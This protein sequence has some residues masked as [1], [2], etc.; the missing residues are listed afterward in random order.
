MKEIKKIRLNKNNQWYFSEFIS[1]INSNSFITS[2]KL[3]FTLLKVLINNKSYS[4]SNEEEN[5]KLNDTLFTYSMQFSEMFNLIERDNEY[6]YSNCFSSTFEK[7]FNCDIFSEKIDTFF[8]M[9][10]LFSDLINDWR[11]IE[12][13]NKKKC[14]TINIVKHLSEKANIEPDEAFIDSVSSIIDLLQKFNVIDKVDKLFSVDSRKLNNLKSEIYWKK[15]STLKKK[16]KDKEISKKFIEYFYEI[17]GLTN[18]TSIRI[19]HLL[20]HMS[21]KMNSPYMNFERFLK[22]IPINYKN[23]NIYLQQGR[24]VSRGDLVK[25]NKHFKYIEVVKLI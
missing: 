12:F 15:Y 1:I 22:I 6:I 10:L 21:L 7:N 5:I 16:Y 23:Y 20:S 24:S 17:Q 8:G 19:V 3:R 11:I 4:K 2:K 13:I 14:K 25:N 18:E 9:I